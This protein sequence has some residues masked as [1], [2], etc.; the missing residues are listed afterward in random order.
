MLA[1]VSG[2][3]GTS[4][5]RQQGETWRR[6]RLLMGGAK[7]TAEP[8]CCEPKWQQRRQRWG[9]P[10]RSLAFGVLDRTTHVKACVTAPQELRGGKGGG[11]RRAERPIPILPEVTTH[12]RTIPNV[13]HTRKGPNDSH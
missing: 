8:Q 7:L 10:G 1:K 5:C 12:G 4:P 9:T 6:R 3:T 2:R 13:S 11:R